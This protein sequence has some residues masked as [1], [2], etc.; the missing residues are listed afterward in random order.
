MLVYLEHVKIQQSLLDINPLGLG[1]GTHTHYHCCQTKLQRITQVDW[2]ILVKLLKNE[3]CK[4]L[5]N[6]STPTV[7]QYGERVHEGPEIQLKG[8]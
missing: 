7:D 8:L 4:S 1:C 2:L 3:H 6:K 5:T